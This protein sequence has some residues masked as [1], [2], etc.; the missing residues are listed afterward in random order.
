M[1]VIFSSIGDTMSLHEA[2][3]RGLIIAQE[4]D[5]VDTSRLSAA[6]A[7][8][9]AQSWNIRAVIDTRTNEHL[10]VEEAIARGILD[11]EVCFIFILIELLCLAAYHT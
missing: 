11:K 3:E 8:Y 10:S 9:Q 6:T 2:Y 5:S 1:N 7:Q 4:S